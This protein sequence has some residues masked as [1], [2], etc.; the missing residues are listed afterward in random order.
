MMANYSI[1]LGVQPPQIDTG[2][3]LELAA[4]LRQQQLAGQQAQQGMD[5]ERQ[6]FGLQQQKFQSAQSAE[7][8]QRNALS[9]Y[10]KAQQGGDQ[11]ALQKLSAYP[12]LQSKVLGIRNQMSEA[13]RDQFDQSLIRNARRAQTVMGLTGED[14]QQAW[15]A[16]LQDSLQAGD[17][18]PELYQQY[19]AQQP[20]DLLLHNIVQQAVPIQSL[21]QQPTAKMQEL[22][23][24]GIAPGTPEYKAQIV[25]PRYEKI[26]DR[27]IRLDGPD[28]RPVDETPPLADGTLPKPS[29]FDSPQ[30]RVKYEQNLRKEY[31]TSSKTFQEVRD[32]AARVEASAK[33]ASPAGDL[34]LIFNYMKVLDPGSVVRESEFATAASSGSYGERIQ[35]MVNRIISGERLTDTMREDFLNRSRKL[36]GAQANQFEK[37]TK[38]FRNIAGS[39][40]VN[41]EDVILDYTPAPGNF[42]ELDAGQANPSPVQRPRARNPETGEVVE[43]NDQT[44]QWEPVQ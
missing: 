1:A 6:R 5:L 22:E 17:I 36:Y 28:G 29:I 14:K 23:A 4:R 15:Q 40:G 39:A 18:T 34:A 44:G 2:N 37:M 27:L 13:Q 41:S 20:N 21:Y 10:N 7:Q 33:N 16:E 30:D 35:G 38:Q 3:A 19:A 9:E 26:K 24:A 12:D 8:A 31:T 32:A 42:P 25:L 43:Y 11:N